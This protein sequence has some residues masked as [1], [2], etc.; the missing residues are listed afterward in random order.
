MTDTCFFYIN[1]EEREHRKIQL[2]LYGERDSLMKNK[3]DPALRRTSYLSKEIAKRTPKSH[4]TN[5][6]IY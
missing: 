4:E 2:R 1:T 3:P 6:S 5:P